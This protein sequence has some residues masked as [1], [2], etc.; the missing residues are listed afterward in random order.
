MWPPA[1]RR[2][3]WTGRGRT[4]RRRPLRPT[5]SRTGETHSARLVVDVALRKLLAV[6]VEREPP[7]GCHGREGL[8][9]CITDQ[10]E[11]ASVVLGQVAR[12]RA[13][14]S[15]QSIQHVGDPVPVGQLRID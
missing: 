3:A 6:G 12:K 7:L 4:R 9:R 5:R 1:P 14:Y 11:A 8:Y 15:V 13:E 2:R 10:R